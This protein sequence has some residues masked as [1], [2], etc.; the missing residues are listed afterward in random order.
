[1]FLGGKA[2]VEG[3]RNHKNKNGRLLNKDQAQGHI[4]TGKERV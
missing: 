2:S 1:M 4:V 3:R